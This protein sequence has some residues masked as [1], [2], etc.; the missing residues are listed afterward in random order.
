MIGAATR[1]CV[2]TATGGLEGRGDSAVKSEYEACSLRMVYK[3]FIEFRRNLAYQ[4]DGQFD[5]SLSL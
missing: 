2:R 4:P 5:N 3:L 1:P